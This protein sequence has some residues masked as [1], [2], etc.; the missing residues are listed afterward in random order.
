[1]FGR[2]RV[3]LCTRSTSPAYRKKRSPSIS[4]TTPSRSAARVSTSR[5]RTGASSVTSVPSESSRGRWPCR[6]GLVPAKPGALRE[7]RARSPRRE[8]RTVQTAPHPGHDDRR[9]RIRRLASTARVL[10]EAAS[11][12][13]SAQRDRLRGVRLLER[14]VHA[15]ATREGRTVDPD[16]QSQ[17]GYEPTRAV[18]LSIRPGYS[19]RRRLLDPHLVDYRGQRQRS[20][21]TQPC[22]FVDRSEVT[23]GHPVREI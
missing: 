6:R 5:S 4:R 11:G 10:R 23:I 21:G 1:M 15:P 12:R 16:I 18:G 22:G 17:M 14:Q 9:G 20:Q 13:L 19:H 8:A 3:S 7:R 2:P